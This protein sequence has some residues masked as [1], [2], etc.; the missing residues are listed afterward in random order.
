MQGIVNPSSLGLETLAK[1]PEADGRELVPGVYSYVDTQG[2]SGWHI[3][4][5]DPRQS[6]K[7]IRSCSLLSPA[8]STLASYLGCRRAL[9]LLDPKIEKLHGQRI[10]AYFTAHGIAHVDFCLPRRA[11]PE[12]N[13]SFQVLGNVSTWVLDQ[14]PDGDDVIVIF[15]GGVLIDLGGSVA[16]FVRRGLLPY[17]SIPTTPIAMVD[18]AV[19]PK[20]AVNIGSH[21]NGGGGRYAPEVVLMDTAFLRTVDH[22]ALLDGLSE[23]AKI[24]IVGDARLFDVIEEFGV[25]LVRRHFQSKLGELVLCRSI[26]SFLTLKAQLG[27]PSIRAFGHMFSKLL[28]SLSNYKLTHGEAVAIEQRIA[29]FLSADEG[30][31][32]ANDLERLQSWFDQIGLAS[33]ADVCDTSQI[34][35]HVFA[36]AY[37][38]GR[39]FDF[40][41]PGRQIG[42][43]TFLKRFTRQQLAVA[44][45]QARK[46]ASDTILRVKTGRSQKRRRAPRLR[47]LRSTA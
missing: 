3:L 4:D 33:F 36:K 34:W 12:S 5:R 47:F 26:E 22:S 8:N 18:A 44:I 23:I 2:N 38:K 7:V 10:R 16:D 37:Q 31:L 6:F 25:E 40:P 17:V 41:L 21:K 30:L 11:I 46:R 32:N 29:A 9:C 39:S 42:K 24:A 28:E 43:G 20:T 14:D 45:S 15:G 13:K 1:Q 19:S 27:E 35:D